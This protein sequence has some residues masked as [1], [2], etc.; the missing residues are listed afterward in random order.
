MNAPATFT[1]NPKMEYRRLGRSGL[2]V[3]VLSFG[4]WVTFHKQIDDKIADELMGIAYEQGVNFF[5]NAEIYALGESENM[6]GRVLKKKKWDRTSYCVSS[7]VYFGWRGEQSRIGERHTLA[8][9]RH[10]VGKNADPAN[11]FC[12]ALFFAH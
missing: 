8:G 11:S 2:K 9:N 4:S 5:D 1:P 7:K 12:A 3:S 10:L 6:M